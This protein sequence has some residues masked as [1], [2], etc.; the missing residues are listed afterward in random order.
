MLHAQESIK[1]LLKFQI[2]WRLFAILARLLQSLSN[3]AKSSIVDVWHGSDYASDASTIFASSIKRKFV[4]KNFIGFFSE[5]SVP[6]YSFQEIW[7]YMS[8]Q[9][10]TWQKW[11]NKL[12]N[13]IKNIHKLFMQL[14]WV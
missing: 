7:Y 4:D 14:W 11:A 3:F 8:E 13:K 10:Y 12:F 9:V 1:I 6:A 2:R 5:I